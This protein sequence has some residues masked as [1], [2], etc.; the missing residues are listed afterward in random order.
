MAH[1][2]DMRAGRRSYRWLLWVPFLLGFFVAVRFWV[3]PHLIYDAYATYLPYPSFSTDSAFLHASFSQAGGPVEYASGFLSQWFHDPTIGALVLTGIAMLLCLA[4]GRLLHLAGGAKWSLWALLPGVGIAALYVQ[5]EHPLAVLLALAVGLWFAVGYLWLPV[6]NAPLRIG[7]F[8]IAAMVLYYLA[9]AVAILFGV[10][11]GLGELFG[12]RRFIVGPIV[13]LVSIPVPWLIGMEVFV[14][15]SGEAYSLLW[16]FG[17]TGAAG[18]EPV[19]SILRALFLYP[20]AILLATGIVVLLLGTGI[21]SN[22]RLAKKATP[23]SRTSL[24]R[25]PAF[26]AAVPVLVLGA[27]IGAT[28]WRLPDG[29]RRS[30]FQ[31]VHHTRE[32]RWEA[33]LRAAGGLSA[34]RYDHFCNHMVNLALYHSGR[35]A[36]AMFSFPQSRSG[37]L[38]FTKDV[39][40]APPKYWMLAETSLD[41]GNLNLAEQWAYETFET[42]GSCGW[43]LKLLGAIYAA[44]EQPEVARVYLARLKKDLIHWREA[45]ELMACVE[46]GASVR[47]NWEQ[48]FLNARARRWD[49]DSVYT[50]YPEEFALKGLLDADG[51]NRMAF[52][53]LMAYYLLA[54]QPGR[55]AENLHHLDALGY[56]TIPRHYQEAIVVHSAATKQPVNLHGR[57]IDPAVVQQFR[58]FSDRYRP[59]RG[60]KEAAARALARDFGN[61]YF[62]YHM[63]GFSGVGAMR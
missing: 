16:P 6:E 45:D 12:R 10:A 11:A 44:K 40:H 63:F 29:H 17:S 21:R 59:L 39:P 58:T 8:A 18:Y 48:R 2:R 23:R 43:V 53:Y 35:F 42:E 28:A 15:T 61:T 49:R 52:E 54:K 25:R 38:L 46:T 47:G 14:M 34:R 57:Q 56:E 37:L 7:T 55:V 36:D 41:M 32:R 9:G 27:L 30:L 1:N 60:R 31:M 19:L 13:A 24:I 20:P 26:Q 50:V 51:Q 33:V 22:G 5:Y 3:K 62:Y 4:V